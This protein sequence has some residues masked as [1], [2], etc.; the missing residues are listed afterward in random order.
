MTKIWIET[1]TGTLHFGTG[2]YKSDR[3]ATKEEYMSADR[4]IGSIFES[5]QPEEQIQFIDGT[6]LL[7]DDL[8]PVD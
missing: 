5:L 2:T 7:D 4:S 6:F 3:L 1:K 8:D